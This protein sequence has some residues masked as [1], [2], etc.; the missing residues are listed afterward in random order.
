[1]I[2]LI[3]VIKQLIYMLINIKLNISLSF[4]YIF[5]NFELLAKQ[6]K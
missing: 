4:M 1:M 6:K 5:K 2:L 3:F